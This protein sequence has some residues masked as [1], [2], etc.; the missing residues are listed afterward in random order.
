MTTQYTVNG[1]DP[2]ELLQNVIT[3][4]SLHLFDVAMV[5]GVLQSLERRFCNGEAR[6]EWITGQAGAE[7]VTPMVAVRLV[8]GAG[9]TGLGIYLDLDFGQEARIRI[10]PLQLT[11]REGERAAPLRESEYKEKAP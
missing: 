1:D 7:S 8:T 5:D 6:A 11:E 9:D 10:R 3:H 4:L 2:V